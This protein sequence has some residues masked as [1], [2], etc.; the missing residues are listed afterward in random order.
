MKFPAILEGWRYGNPEN[1]MD[2]VIALN[3]RHEQQAEKPKSVR[4]DDYYRQ[5]RSIKIK[6]IVKRAK[7][8]GFK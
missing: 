6:E 1:I 4:K 7:N 5:S 2:G 8:G 3:R